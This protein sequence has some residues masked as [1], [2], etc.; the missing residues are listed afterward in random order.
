MRSSRRPGCWRRSRARS[1][2]RSRSAS[3][4]SETARAPAAPPQRW[5]IAASLVAMV[6]AGSLRPPACRERSRPRRWR[7][8]ARPRR[9]GPRRYGARRRAAGARR[10]PPAPA[11]PLGEPGGAS[12]LC[13]R[14]R[15]RSPRR[16][17]R[18]RVQKERQEL[19]ALGYVAG[20]RRNGG[21]VGSREESPEGRSRVSRAAAPAASRR[22]GRAGACRGG[23]QPPAEAEAQARCVE[24]SQSRRAPRGPLGRTSGKTARGS[25]DTE[26]SRRRFRPP[27]RRPGAHH[28][29]DQRRRQRDRPA[30][31]LRRS[32][33][34]LRRT[35]ARHPVSTFRLDAGTAADARSRRDLPAAKARRSATSIRVEE[36]VARATARRPRAV[37]AEGAPTPFVRDRAP[38]CCASTSAACPL[39]ARVEVD[40]NPAVV[41]R[42]RLIGAGAAGALR[43]R[44]ADRTLRATAGWRPCVW[45]IGR[46]TGGR[47][48]SPGSP[49]PGRRPRRG[50]RLAALAAGSPR[51]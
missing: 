14:L 35:S 22:P 48:R 7:S 38:G 13:R 24:E 12:G 11:E 26:K 43:D 21:R 51:S 20:P 17:R 29:P 1:R 23:P 25:T 5:L 37:T 10:S 40:F 18:S 50:F 47:W 49:R 15:L 4:T 42:Y 39:G 30:E 33:P 27:G 2:R 9:R 16:S 31:R 45:S 6:G 44:A 46:G 41:V 3:A 36:L 28:G 19:Q 8:P 34:S 32:G